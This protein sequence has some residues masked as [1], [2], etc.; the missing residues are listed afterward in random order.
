MCGIAGCALSGRGSP[1]SSLEG[2]RRMMT[3]MRSRGPDAEG[4]LSADGVVLGHRRL[5]ILDL[6]SRANQPMRSDDTR[7]SIVFNGEI[8]NFRELRKTLERQGVLFRTDVGHRGPA[9]AVREGRSCH[10]GPSAWH[11]RHGH[12]GFA[13]S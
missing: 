3:R 13:P 2:T 11:V 12:L 1:E 4:M 8:Y 9:G 10:A 6:A 7:Y 5:A